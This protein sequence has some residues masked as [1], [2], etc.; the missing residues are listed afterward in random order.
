MVLQTTQ[1]EYKAGLTVHTKYLE[2]SQLCKLFLL[3]HINS[4]NVVKLGQQLLN[5]IVQ[6]IWKLVKHTW[7]TQTPTLKHHI[8]ALPLL[9][10]SLNSCG[11]LDL[12]PAFPSCTVYMTL[13]LCPVCFM[14]ESQYV[15]RER[16]VW[17]AVEVYKRSSIKTEITGREPG[18]RAHTPLLGG[19]ADS[20]ADRPRAGSS[21]SIMVSL[22]IIYISPS[23]PLLPTSS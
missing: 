21:V 22:Q 23:S 1:K 16:S 3:F 11:L 17:T 4:Y 12:L 14:A 19:R 9:Q 7:H 15:D 5:S 20:T 13:P 18:Q 6:N 10:R 8:F 2:W